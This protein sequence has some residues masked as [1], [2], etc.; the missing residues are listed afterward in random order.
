MELQLVQIQSKIYELRG[1]Q[2]MFDFDLAE[3]YQVETKQLNQSVKRNIKRFPADFMFQLTTEEWKNLKSQ[4][5]TS[6]WGGA[7]KLPFAFTEQGLAML[8]G[9]LNSDIAIEANIMIMRTFV[10]VRRFL[11]IPPAER[12]AVL[13]HE[14]K[15]LKTSI[16]EKRTSKFLIKWNYNSVKFKVKSTKFVVNK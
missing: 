7:R 16:E 15:E 3:A 6:S 5:V 1:R 2:V 4:F 9:I 14:V 13:E 8:S 12:L 10:A 11:S